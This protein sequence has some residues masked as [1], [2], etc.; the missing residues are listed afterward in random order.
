MFRKSFFLLTLLVLV[1]SACNSPS[2]LFKKGKKKFDAF[3][4]Q[5]AIDFFEKARKGGYNP[6][7]SNYGIAE[8]YRLSNRIAQ[9]EPFY[10]AALDNG[11]KQE[12]ARFNYAYSLKAAGKYKEAAA[13]FEQYAKNGNNLKNRARA[14]K[15]LETLPQIEEIST[16]K[17]Q[18]EVENLRLLNTEASEFAPVPRQDQL[19][20]TASL[21][22]K[23]YKAN[24]L[25]MLGLYAVPMSNDTTPN[26][27]PKLFSDN[28]NEETVN[29]GTPA[30]SPDG[31]RM[32]FSRS[33]GRRQDP[34][35]ETDLYQS[36]LKDGNWSEPERL[37]ISSTGKNKKGG[38]DGCPA[39]SRDGKTL[40]FASNREGG[41]GGLDL[42]QAN[43]D[44]SGR[45]RGVRNMGTSLN[46]AG[47]EMFPYVSD[48]GKLYF[49]SDG[50]P[51]LGGLDLFV[52][53][54]QNSEINVKNLGVPMNSNG[55]DFGISFK[56][57]TFG[58]FTSNRDGGKGDD[59]IYTFKDKSTDRKIV[60]Y[61][62]AGTVV[63]K[64]TT[65]AG[66]ELVLADAKV[67]VSLG[68]N[69]IKTFTTDGQGRFGKVAV[70]AGKTY[71]LK[72]DKNPTF[73][74]QELGFSM[75]GKT[76]PQESLTKPVTD[77][78][79]E[80][81]IELIPQRKGTVF[82]VD[83]ILYDFDKW[84]IRPDAAL[85]LDKLV[86]FLNNNQK[87]QVELS[88]H[89]D[90][91]GSGKYNDVLS[92]KRAEAA[93]AYIVSKG[94]TASRITA[95]GYGK[96]RLLVENAQTEDEHQKNRRTEIEI[97]KVEE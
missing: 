23:T 42:Y 32:V 58:Y 48:D 78:T 29:E 77:T 59:D 3:E 50:L 37:D 55:D 57:P 53:T 90:D 64:D 40:Y 10:K 28:I 85:E 27:K 79:Y 76:L 82:A 45:F 9:A 25:G 13:Q 73:L 16:A 95:K 21:K 51:G 86:T 19:L 6:P 22:D 1:V 83:N 38:W 36:V 31:K 5:T 74:V 2:A 91:R 97:T 35:V 80:V 47:N 66:Q 30:F 81:K 34:G 56:T 72:A 14:K 18:Y 96:N 20:L 62:L 89:T 65:N 49:S 41:Y 87:I 7:Q 33:N 17:T 54:R 63:F 93:V 67:E 15:E 11:T 75:L 61:Y 24:G 43:L 44:G 26:G 84:D 60:N 94:I 69:V 92:Q 70:Q 39:F 68:G 71:D 8:S 12:A 46:T 4:Y 88:S 52:A